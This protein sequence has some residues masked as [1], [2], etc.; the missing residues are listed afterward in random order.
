M[1]NNNDNISFSITEQTE[2]DD[3]NNNNNNI[4]SDDEELNKILYELEQQIIINEDITVPYMINYREN[5]TIKELLQICDYYGIVKEYKLNKCNKD[6]II[7]FLLNFELNLNNSE[8]VSRRKNMWFYISELKNDK[9]MK[10][11]VIW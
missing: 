4:V 7:D 10:K 6:Q 11:Y 8:T 3:T 2:T 1:S 5:Y 9:F